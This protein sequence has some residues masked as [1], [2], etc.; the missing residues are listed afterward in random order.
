M[1]SGALTEGV[2]PAGRRCPVCEAG[3]LLYNACRHE[4]DPMSLDPSDLAAKAAAAPRTG[5]AFR[6]GFAAPRLLHLPFAGL[7]AAGEVAGEGGMA[8]PG[9]VVLD[10]LGSDGSS[11]R[12][13]ETTI[14]LPAPGAAPAAFRFEFRDDSLPAG[15]GRAIATLLDGDDAV[16]AIS[17]VETLVL[18]VA[19]LPLRDQQVALPL[20]SMRIEDLPAFPLGASVPAAGEGAD[21]RLVMRAPAPVQ[22][23][24]MDAADL[25]GMLA[26]NG[27]P[28]RFSQR[29]Y[30]LNGLWVGVMHGATVMGQTGCVVG[31]GGIADESWGA[32]HP[33][34]PPFYQIRPFLEPWSEP[35]RCGDVGIWWA[36]PWRKHNYYHTHAE[37]LAALVQLEMF[38]DLGGAPDFDIL[39]PDLSGWTKEAVDLLGLDDRRVR[40]IGRRCLQPERLYWPSA[41]LRMN[42]GIEPLLRSVCRRI[43]AAALA[44]AEAGTLRLPEAAGRPELIYVARTDSTIRPMLNEP[45][46]I[47]AL[48]ARGVRIFVSAELGYAQQ[49]LTASRARVVIAPHGA[50]LTNIGFAAR[51]ALVV[52][53]HPHFY[54]SPLYLRFAQVLG[55]RYRA[56]TA[57]EADPAETEAKAWRLDVPAFLAFLDPL[58][59]AEA[60]AGRI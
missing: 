44:R 40:T 36:A 21:H 55:Q 27:L 23:L 22:L 15:P 6:I 50:G 35:E 9:R 18:R 39:L 51:D 33:R 4:L 1:R 41:V 48:R 12:R 59:E 11:L 2:A 7:R 54:T 5:D 42:V 60:K 46:L 24:P 38:R 13:E 52:E 49:V 43:R 19:D 8:G 57:P 25:A 58:L 45:E 34:T 29:S 31:A 20:R 28:K 56:F 32:L 10:W 37:P 30:P 16:L 47:E 26:A 17:A 14:E 3:E 53:I